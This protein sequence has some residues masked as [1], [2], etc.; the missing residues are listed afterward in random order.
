MD[1][2]TGV[3]G[4][5]TAFERLEGSWEPRT[6]AAVDDHRVKVARLDGAFVWHSHPTDELFL[7]HDG[8]LEIEF[9]EEPTATLEAG[10][11]LT[12]PA[13]VE[14]RPVAPERCEVL[15]IERAGTENTGDADA[16]DRAGEAAWLTG[17]RP[18]AAAT[19]TDDPGA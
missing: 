2:E 14:H 11:L 13:G 6:V 9:R 1:T 18:H 19:E 17:R 3:F 7:V 5:A 16:P 4:L 12:V 8:R 15:L 10:D